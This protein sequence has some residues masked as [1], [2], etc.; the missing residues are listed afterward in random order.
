MQ[1]LISVLV[2]IKILGCRKLTVNTLLN[3][4]LANLTDSAKF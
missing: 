2:K 1:N 4:Y 3:Q